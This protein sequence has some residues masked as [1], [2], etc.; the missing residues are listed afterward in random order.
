MPARKAKKQDKGHAKLLFMVHLPIVAV[1][2]G[3]PFVTDVSVETIWPI[4]GIYIVAK[5]MGWLAL[6]FI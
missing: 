3:V 1:L 5:F 4:W 6:K 2:V